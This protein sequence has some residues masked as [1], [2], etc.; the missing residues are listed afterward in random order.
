[1]LGGVMGEEFPEL[2][3]FRHGQVRVRGGLGVYG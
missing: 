1:M 2:T 3:G